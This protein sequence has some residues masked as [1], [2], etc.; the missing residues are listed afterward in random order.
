MQRAPAL[1]FCL[2]ECVNGYVGKYFFWTD[3]SYSA[4]ELI[5]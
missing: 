3:T 5:A 2:E 4:I 1:F